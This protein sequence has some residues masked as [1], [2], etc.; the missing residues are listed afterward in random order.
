MVAAVFTV[1]DDV[2]EYY[3]M[4]SRSLQARQGACSLLVWTAIQHATTLGLQFDFAGIKDAT[5]LR[6]LS[7]FGGTLHPRF[8]V[9]RLTPSYRVLNALYRTAAEF[10]YKFTRN[11]V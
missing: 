1:W 3:L 4:T 7:G 11:T 2:A 5:A 8:T 9:C 10:H 6:F